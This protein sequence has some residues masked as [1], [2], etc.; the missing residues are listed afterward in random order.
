M[1]NKVN[2]VPEG[3]HTATPYLI[4]NDAAAALEFYKQ[5]F[6]ATEL[7]RMAKP[8]GKVGH[9][10][11]KIDDSILMLADEAPE[12]G[13]RS[14]ES[15]GGSPVSILLYLDDVDRVFNQA[16]AA[17]AKVQQALTNKFYGDRMG[18]VIDPFGHVWYVATHVEDVSPEEMQKRAAAAAA[19]D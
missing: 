18:G 12:V 17:G 16:V 10:E 11:F 14:P 15:L 5:A 8:D 3:Y 7:F 1:P 6:G 19:H 2:P 9:A 13:A 4:V